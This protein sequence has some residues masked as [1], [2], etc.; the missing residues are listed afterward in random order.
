[1]SH[2]RTLYS[3]LWEPQISYWS[4]CLLHFSGGIG[5]APT[6][7]LVCPSCYCQ[8]YYHVL[9][10]SQWGFELVIG[11]ID[12]FTTWLV[13]TLNYSTITVFQTLHIITARIKSFQSAFTSRFLVTDLNNRHSS[14]APTKSPLHRLLYNWLPSKLF[15][16]I[17]PQHRPTENT[18]ILFFFLVFPWEHVCLL[19]CYPVTVL[20][21]KNLLPSSGC[22]FVVCFDIITQ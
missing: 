16:L 18:A 21:I 5:V 22:C 4:P 3:A 15:P 9:N 14:T 10:D 7:Q 2:P 11:F 12:H 17:T 6:S 8:L 1:V 20:L 19:R 13:A